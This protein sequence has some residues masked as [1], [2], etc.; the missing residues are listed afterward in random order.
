MADRNID[1]LSEDTD[2][3]T[4]DSEGNPSVSYELSLI[5]PM[6][7]SLGDVVTIDYEP[8]DIDITL[9]IVSITTDPYNDDNISF[10]ISNTVP[11]MEEAAYRIETETVRKDARMNGCRIG[12]TYGFEAVQNDNFA[13]SYFN[14]SNFAMQQ[15]DGSGSNWVNV[16]YFDPAAKKYKITGDVQI[17]GQ[18]A[19]DA[20]FTDSLYAEQGDISQLTVDWIKTS[21][22]LWKY[23]NDDFT[24]DDFTEIHAQYIRQTTAAIKDPHVEVQL[25]NRYGDL[26]YW[27]GDITAATL[28]A[29]G[30]PEIDGTR[31]YTQKTESEW[32]VMVYEYIETVKLS[33]GFRQDPGGSG[34]NFPM[35]ELGAG[36]GTGDN[37]KGFVYK[38]LSGLYLDY[39]S[40][41]N[42]D[43]RRII[44][45]DDGIVLTPYGLNSIDFYGNGFN[46]VYDGE[47]V[48]YTWTKDESGRI[49]SLI[50]EDLVTIP[51]TRHEEDM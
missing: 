49:T 12:P 27:N 2:K 39:Y 34:F 3:T 1:V 45:G 32:P 48:A 38:G 37:G 7:L 11:A 36:T 18:L 16:I 42:G 40:S 21:N 47:T 22:R 50:T 29:D 46:A 30:W 15:G 19:S 23:L 20:D 44:L 28:N 6:A 41:V 31:L 24:D 35:I 26:L 43:L 13:R 51:V 14:A 4:L 33:I 10:A 8:M 9:R 17:E 25:Q 5:Q